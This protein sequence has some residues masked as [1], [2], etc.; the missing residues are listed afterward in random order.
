MKYINKQILFLVLTLISSNSFARNVDDGY[1]YDE[2]SGDGITSFFTSEF[3]IW[4][5][6]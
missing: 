1:N 6:S 3:T 5:K 2:I 4:R